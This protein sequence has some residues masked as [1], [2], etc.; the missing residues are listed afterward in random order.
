M[1]QHETTREDKLERLVDH[2]IDEIRQDS[3]DTVLRSIVRRGFMGFQNMSDARLDSE[4]RL[5]G[6]T[7][8]LPEQQEPDDVAEDM[9]Q[10]I[11][12]LRPMGDG[13]TK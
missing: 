9:A 6:L 12:D 8:G 3:T 1:P 5:R 7:S 10:D 2:L 11:N 13:C 4:L